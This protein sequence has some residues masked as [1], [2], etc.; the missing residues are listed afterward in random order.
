MAQPLLAY[1]HCGILHIHQ[2]QQNKLAN[3]FLCRYRYS[4]LTKTESHTF[5][6]RNLLHISHFVLLSTF[7][8][9][10]NVIIPIGKPS[11]QLGS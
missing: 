2:W 8:S 3:I 5:E 4:H 9:T 7:S 1:S 11:T 6:K 10:L